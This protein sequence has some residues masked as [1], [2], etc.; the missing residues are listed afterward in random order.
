IGISPGGFNFRGQIDEVNLFN[1]PLTT[2]EMLAIFNAK[3]GGMCKDQVNHPPAVNAGPD[4]T[5]TVRDTAT[6]QGTAT[7]D[8]KPV[9]STLAIKW[10]VVSGPGTVTFENPQ[11]ASTTA[12]F[13]LPGTYVLRLTAN[14]SDLI[15]D[16]DV[17][18]T[19]NP[20]A[21]NQPPTVSAGANQTIQIEQTA[22]LNGT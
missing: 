11:Q 22:T 14:D 13:S 6:L 9:G 2:L 7:D 16:D 10:S 12:T 21:G 1:R 17:I 15:S 19:V 4:Q 20:S 8:G 18:V 3:S 5:I